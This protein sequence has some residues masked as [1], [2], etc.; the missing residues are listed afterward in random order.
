MGTQRAFINIEH[1]ESHRWGPPLV[2]AD[3]HAFCQAICKGVEGTT[4]EELYFT[5]RL[6]KAQEQQASES[7]SKSPFRLKAAKDCVEGFCDPARND[8][9]LGRKHSRLELWEDPLKDPIEALDE[10][11]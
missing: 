9:I 11:L 8:N 1:I 10:A 5:T 2:G 7:K 3:W 6:S 4:W